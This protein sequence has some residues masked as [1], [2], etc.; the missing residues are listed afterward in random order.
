MSFSWC[1]YRPCN[2]VLLRQTNIY[3][4]LLSLCL[5]V[6]TSAEMSFSSIWIDGQVTIF[7]LMMCWCFLYLSKYKVYDELVLLI[8]Y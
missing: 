5:V 7:P 1:H 8:F 2:V 4:Y 3:I 6:H